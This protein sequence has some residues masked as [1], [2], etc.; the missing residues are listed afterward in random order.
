MDLYDFW[1]GWGEDEGTANERLLDGTRGAYVL[2]AM[3]KLLASYYKADGI[4]R[5]PKLNVNNRY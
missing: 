5:F 4:Q 3:G 1:G 2:N